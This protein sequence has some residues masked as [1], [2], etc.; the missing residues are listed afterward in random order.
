MD[1]KFQLLLY[2]TNKMPTAEDFQIRLWTDKFRGTEI[3]YQPSIVGHESE[4]LS[5]ILETTLNYF[6]RADARFRP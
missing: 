6:G 5:E 2:S 4:G 1:P 3:L